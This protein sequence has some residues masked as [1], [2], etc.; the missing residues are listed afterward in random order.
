MTLLLK[1]SLNKFYL[2]FWITLET[3]CSR[4]RTG[5]CDVCYKL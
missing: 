4:G 5:R 2:H 1:G 3:L